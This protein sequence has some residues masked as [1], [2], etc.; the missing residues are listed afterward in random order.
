VLLQARAIETRLR[1]GAPRRPACT[2]GAGKPI[3]A[4]RWLIDPWEKLCW[5]TLE[6]SVGPGPVAPIDPSHGQ[7]VPGRRNA[8]PE[9]PLSLAVLSLRM[10]SI[11]HCWGH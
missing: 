5:L 9:P 1:A 11:D 2:M 3:G 8:E 7:R 6:V 10:F 4:R